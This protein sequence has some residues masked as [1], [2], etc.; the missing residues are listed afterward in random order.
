MKLLGLAV[1]FLTLA[2]S[3]ARAQPTA[4]TRSAFEYGYQGLYTGAILGLGAGYL[5]ARGDGW[6]NDADWRPLAY[7]V[8]IGALAGAVGGLT[9]GVIDIAR[10]TPGV[11]YVGL[12]GMGYGALFGA[13]AGGIAGGLAALSTKEA[14][15]I[16]LGASIGSLVGAGVGL[17]LGIFEGS[18]RKSRSTA[19]MLPTVT[20][21]ADADRQLVW[22]PA[23][24]ARY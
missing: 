9:L 12:Q 17:G 2:A 16:L 13:T 21:A 3:P 5:F 6:D 15:H 24:V 14:E 19:M 4:S 7:G 23:L 22:M 8:G 18:R 10:E 20:L 11:A 1:L